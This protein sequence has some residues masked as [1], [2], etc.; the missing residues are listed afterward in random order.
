MRILTLDVESSFLLAGVWSLWSNH[1]AL[2]QL[3]STGQLLSWAAKWK[4]ER[5][6]KSRWWD[7]EEFLP[8][9]HAL[10]DEADVVISYNGKR[11]DIP[12]IN[13]EFI[14]AGYKPPSPFKQIDLLET[15]KKQF[16][17]PSNKLEF[18]L[19]DFEVGAKMKHEGFELW[20][21]CM[22]GDEQAK[23][24]MTRYNRKDVTE[25]EKLYNKLKGWIVGAPNAALYLT[26]EQLAKKG[27]ICPS[28]GGN[29]LHS[30]GTAKTNTGVFARFQC[31]DCG[32][33]SRSRYT[34]LDKDARKS[35]LMN[36]AL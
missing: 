29:H 3:L 1:T 20:I 19:K 22:H 15:I 34:E 26:P 13:R 14:K 12:M 27:Q 33:W 6:V 24:K 9:L 16:K 7:E 17:L 23:A 10:L 11:F 18:V 31:V 25:T 21:K 8:E 30:R 28:C 32:H 4:G 36:I 5:E 2:S 35:V